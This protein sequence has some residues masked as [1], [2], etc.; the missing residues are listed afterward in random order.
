MFDVDAFLDRAKAGAGVESDYAL[1]VKVLGY[2]KASTVYNWRSG[3]SAPD[4]RAI[5]ALCKH[6]G[7]DPEHV[8]ACIQSMR[9]ANDDEAFLWRRIADRLQKGFATASLILVLAILL[10]AGHTT[11]VQTAALAFLKACWVSVYYVNCFVLVG[12]SRCL[13]RLWGMTRRNA[14]PSAFA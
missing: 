1:A 7:D 4:G 10:V 13:A 11:P 12:S 3:Y 6:S 5:I 2:K 14:G 9:A 8:A